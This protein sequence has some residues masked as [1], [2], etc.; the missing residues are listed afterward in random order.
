[1]KTNFEK[2]IK[3]YRKAKEVAK[4]ECVT[5]LNRL[6]DENDGEL[7]IWGFGFTITYD[8]GRHPEFA[9]NPY[10]QVNTIYR[11]KDSGEIYF[12]T[13]D[14]DINI[15]YVIGSELIDIVDDLHMLEDEFGSIN[16]ASKEVEFDNAIAE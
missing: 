3:A 9:A 12:E 4:N 10:S 11:K 14:A 16:E 7:S 1:M 5:E 2:A 8:G 6:L 13:E 15:K